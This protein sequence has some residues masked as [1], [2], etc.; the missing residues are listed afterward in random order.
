MN[1]DYLTLALI[2]MTLLGVHFFLV[3][4]LSQQV[5][6]RII[7]FFGQVIIVPALFVYIYVARIS[8]Q[9]EE[10]NYLVYALLASLLL[11][12]GIIALYIAIQKGPVSIVI[13][14]FSLNAVVAAV[15]GILFLEEVIT[16]E[17]VIGI[18]LATAAIF[19]LKQS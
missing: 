13:P 8:F 19:L 2:S 10:V 4:L 1:S 6:G 18:G 7:V 14:V 5:P 12:V 16:I 3:K 17:K 15:L 11:S 9:I